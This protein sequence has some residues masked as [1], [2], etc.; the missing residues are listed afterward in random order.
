MCMFVLDEGYL[1]YSPSVFLKESS[2]SGLDPFQTSAKIFPIGQPFLVVFCWSL[3]L[4][5]CQNPEKAINQNYWP[6]S[7]S[8]P[9]KVLSPS[10]LTREEGTVVLLWSGSHCNALFL[11]CAWFT[12]TPS[13]QWMCLPALVLQP[14]LDRAAHP[15]ESERGSGA[16]PD[17]L[18][19]NTRAEWAVPGALRQ[20]HS[21]NNAFKHF[22]LLIAI[23]Q[24]V[25]KDLNC[26]VK[27]NEISIAACI[28]AWQASA[29]CS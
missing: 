28:A 10:S 20:L 11:C 18:P 9:F 3:N 13:L 17:G 2:W 15:E 6:W 4:Q 19:R 22:A 5:T 1:I 26:Q 24:C 21:L 27:D 29:V 12:K 8:Q 16:L 25:E 7:I 23:E 14:S